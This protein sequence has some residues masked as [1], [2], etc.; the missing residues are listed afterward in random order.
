MDKDGP[1]KYY[2]VLRDYLGNTRVTFSDLNNDDAINEK[3]E[4]IQI[5]NYYAFGLN[6]E[7]NWNGAS[8]TN[9][10]QYNGK[11]LNDDFGL[12]WNDYGFR[13]YDAAVG[14]WWVREPLANSYP[15]VT[16]YNYCFNNPINFIDPLGLDTIKPNAPGRKGDVVPLENGEHLTLSSDDVVVRDK[17]PEPSSKESDRKPEGSQFTGSSANSS[18]PEHLYNFV[19][20]LI[21]TTF[22][23]GIDGDFVLLGAAGKSGDLTVVLK[24]KDA[25][26]VHLVISTRV[27]GGGP[28]SADASVHFSVG[29]MGT[30]NRQFVQD[31][32]ASDIINTSYAFE[33]GESTQSYS[34]FG[35]ITAGFIGG[36]SLNGAHS[37]IKVN[38]KSKSLITWGASGGFTGGISYSSGSQRSQI[39]KSVDLLPFLRKG[40]K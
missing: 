10:Y 21:P 5:N 13:M 7:G 17:K 24:G 23:L 12:N 28:I 30:L 40:K 4:I 34:G 33:D 3:E 15:S 38:S 20:A 18:L 31:L 27:G 9:K 11:E 37:L 36:A 29:H 39:Y 2:F 26:T 8:G 1:F 22:S 6:M 19:Y 32:S 14:R 35:S 25:G 16:P